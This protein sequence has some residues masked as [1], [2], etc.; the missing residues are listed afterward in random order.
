[1]N[2]SLQHPQYLTEINET[3]FSV[4]GPRLVFIESQFLIVLM[5][6]LRPSFVRVSKSR[7]RLRII[8]SS[9]EIKTKTETALSLKIE[10]KNENF[11]DSCKCGPLEYSILS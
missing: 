6:R 8:L 3:G 10:T 9:L 4:S 1:M 11:Q 7:P 5:T 2:I